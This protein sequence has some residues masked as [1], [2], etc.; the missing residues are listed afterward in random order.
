MGVARRYFGTDGIRGVFGTEP[1]TPGFAFAAG[2]ALG[3]W[4]VR[5]HPEPAVIVG[6]DTRASGSLLEQALATGLDQAGAHVELIGVVPTAAV[7]VAVLARGA[8]AGVMISASHNPYP[9]NGIKF[10]GSNGSKLPDVMEAELELLI[11]AE[12]SA[13][14]PGWSFPLSS[15]MEAAPW[16]LRLYR[17]ALERSLPENF[18]LNGMRIVVDGA[19]GAAWHSAPYILRSFGAQV[20]AIHCAPNGTNINEGCG[21]QDIAGLKQAVKDRGP[22]W[23]GL[24]VDGDADRAVLIDEDGTPLD[25]DDLLA[26]LGTARQAAGTLTGN[27]VVATVMSNGGLAQALEQV[28]VT[29]ERTDVGDRYVLE[30]MEATGAVLGG[31]QSG[32]ILFRDIMPTGD[33]LLTALHVLQVSVASG[34]PLKELRKVLVKFPQVLVSLK[35]KRKTPL[36]ELP[37]L[38]AAVRDVESRLQCLGRVHLRYSGTEPKIRLL[39]EGPPEADL[40]SLSEIILKPLRNQLCS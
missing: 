6:R 14:P 26:I 15:S 10:F 27:R 40:E 28:G 38:L 33:G 25:G 13:S 24:A 17:E 22:S 5:H 8:S 35:V 1:M 39:L 20:E 3:R 32:H 23:V 7:S 29:L 2:A 12:L 37:E 9:D 21:S 18:S 36:N 34:K 11:D 19:N 30:R 16:A 31:E 4:L